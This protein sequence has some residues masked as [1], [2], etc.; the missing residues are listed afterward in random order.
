M[1]NPFSTATF[2]HVEYNLYFGLSYHCMLN[3]IF[4]LHCFVLSYHRGNKSTILVIYL[5]LTAQPSPQINDLKPK[6]HVLESVS[7]RSLCQLVNRQM[8]QAGGL[9][10]ASLKGKSLAIDIS[11]CRKLIF[12]PTLTAYEALTNIL[13]NPTFFHSPLICPCPHWQHPTDAQ[14]SCYFTL[15]SPVQA[16]LV[17]R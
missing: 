2:G 17:P 8:W 5:H 3:T 13:L 16:H 4:V 14:T 11:L 7:T 9:Q 12:P 15:R 1:P 6:S 10:M